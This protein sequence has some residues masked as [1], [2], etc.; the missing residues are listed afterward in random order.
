MSIYRAD[1][2][3]IRSD[4]QSTNLPI[5]DGVVPVSLRVGGGGGGGDRGIS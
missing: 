1:C 5:S 2:K 3:C 4:P